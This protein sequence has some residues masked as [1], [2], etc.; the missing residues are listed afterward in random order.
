LPSDDR[1]IA[2]S[3]DF[4]GETA[5]GGDQIAPGDGGLAQSRPNLDG[6]RVGALAELYR[7]AEE[8]ARA[9]D[10]VAARA[11][12]DAASKLLTDAA[13]EPADVIDLATRRGSR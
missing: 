1:E 6:G 12:H 5:P 10:L 4:S 9:G 13:G 2:G 3:L 8:L 7:R 11:L